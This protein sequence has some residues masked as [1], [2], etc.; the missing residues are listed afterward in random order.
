MIRVLHIEPEHVLTKI[1]ELL[2]ALA[3]RIHL[4]R[5]EVEQRV[6]AVLAAKIE[7]AVVLIVIVLNRRGF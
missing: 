3:E 7:H 1:I 4:A 5:Q 2:A 6:V